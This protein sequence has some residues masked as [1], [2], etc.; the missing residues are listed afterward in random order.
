MTR[1]LRRLRGALGIGVAWGL[2]WLGAG[3]VLLLIVG[4]DAADVPFPL[5]FGLLG[6]VAGMIFSGI[7]G[8]TEGRRSFDQMSMRRF[9]SWGAV[10][11]LCLAGIM[12]VILGAESLIVLGPL[13]AVSG[14]VCASGSLA[15]ARRANAASFPTIDVRNDVLEP[16]ESHQLRSSEHARPENH[17]D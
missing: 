4:P 12:A 1:W 15:L 17:T 10:G 2:A 5:F 3:L 14:A 13:F 9:A 6:F 8:M 16:V 11:G 7:L